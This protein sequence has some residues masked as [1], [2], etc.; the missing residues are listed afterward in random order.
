MTHIEDQLAVDHDAWDHVYAGKDKSMLL[1]CAVADRMTPRED[2]EAPRLKIK[3]L[4]VHPD[5]PVPP[6]APEEH[7]A[8]HPVRP[9]CPTW[10]EVCMVRVQDHGTAEGILSQNDTSMQKQQ[11]ITEYMIV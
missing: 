9:A 10:R 6:A 8:F 4:S 7:A 5:D 11:I 2:Q 3:A 1:V